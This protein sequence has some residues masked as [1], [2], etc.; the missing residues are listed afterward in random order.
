MFSK[1]MN[2]IPLRNNAFGRIIKGKEAKKNTTQHKQQQQTQQKKNFNKLVKS[3]SLPIV[4]YIY[5]IVLCVMNATR[6]REAQKKKIVKS[7]YAYDFL[8]LFSSKS[9]TTST[10]HTPSESTTTHDGFN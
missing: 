5:L 3:T 9:S 8:P 6:E 1:A 10:K 4:F 7:H 2:K